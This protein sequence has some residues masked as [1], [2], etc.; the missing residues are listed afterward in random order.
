MTQQHLLWIDLETTGTNENLDSIIE[1]AAILTTPD[2]EVELGQFEA[3]MQPPE[4]SWQRLL[5]NEYVLAMHKANGLYDLIEQGQSEVWPHIGM[6]EDEMMDWLAVHQIRAHRVALAGSGV[7]HF[8]RRFIQAWMPNL[9][10]HLRYWSID[11]GVLRRSWTMWTDSP[12]PSSGLDEAKTHR[13]M[14]D[15]RLH[16]EEARAFRHIFNTPGAQA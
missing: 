14:D 11:V 7:A 13:A 12:L 3:V 5:D 15:V 4:I 9:D 6:V 8:D 1:V 10:N 2:L 16:L